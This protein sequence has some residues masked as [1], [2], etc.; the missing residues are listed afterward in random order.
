MGGRCTGRATI[1]RVIQLVDLTARHSGDKIRSTVVAASAE[2]SPAAAITVAA[3]IL[4]EIVLAT[5]GSQNG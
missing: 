5:A 3:S 2:D 1:G 4:S